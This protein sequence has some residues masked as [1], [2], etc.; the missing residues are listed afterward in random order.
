MKWAVIKVVRYDW[1]KKIFYYEVKEANDDTVMHYR[2]KCLQAS[3]IEDLEHQLLRIYYD[4]QGFELLDEQ[5]KIVF[6][7]RDAE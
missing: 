4:Y 2:N 6:N 7:W 3:S 1:V 5:G